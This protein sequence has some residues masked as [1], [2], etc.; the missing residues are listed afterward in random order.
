VLAFECG[1]LPGRHAYSRGDHGEATPGSIR[2]A[3]AVFDE[4]G[5]ELDM[6]YGESTV[7]V[8]LLGDADDDGTVDA[9]DAVLLQR[10][11]VGEPVDIDTDAADVDTDGD[12]DAGDVLALEKRLVA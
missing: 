6:V 1:A 2:R 7:N 8:D 12:I 9:G 4:N 10:S 11:L 5:T 3:S